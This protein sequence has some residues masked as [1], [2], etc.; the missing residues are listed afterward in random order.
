MDYS[1]YLTNLFENPF[2]LYNYINIIIFRRKRWARFFSRNFFCYFRSINTLKFTF[3]ASKKNCYNLFTHS[4]IRFN[5]CFGVFSANFFHLLGGAF[6]LFF[7]FKKLELHFV[8]SYTKIANT[9]IFLNI[10]YSRKLIS[11]FNPRLSNNF[12]TKFKISNYSFAFLFCFLSYPVFVPNVRFFCN[13]RFLYD[14]YKTSTRLNSFKL[15]SRNSKKVIG[16]LLF[17]YAF[18]LTL[19]ILKLIYSFFIYLNCV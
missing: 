17:G 16:G 6:W 10:F 8:F 11:L 18:H 5:Y 13:L 3:R 19:V 12:I 2:S 7:L 4:L 1:L 15:I 9:I 14:F